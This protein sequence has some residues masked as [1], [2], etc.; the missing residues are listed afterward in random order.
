MKKNL[1]LGV[2]STLLLSLT[3]QL[4]ATETILKVATRQT[5]PFSFKDN[6]KFAATVDLPTPPLPEAMAIT[7]FAYLSFFWVSKGFLFS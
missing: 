6:A 5:P 4:S 1:I 2:I 3:L 7:F